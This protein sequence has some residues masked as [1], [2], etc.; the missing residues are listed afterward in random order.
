MKLDE[1]T[2]NSDESQKNNQNKPM[3]PRKFNH[4]KR[5]ISFA[6]AEDAP[7]YIFIIGN[8]IPLAT[9]DMISSALKKI[10]EASFFKL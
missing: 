2:E 4:G 8:T 1:A 3:P 10:C 6:G 7:I 9:S 5:N